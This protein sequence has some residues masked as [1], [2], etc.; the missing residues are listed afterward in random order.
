MLALLCAHAA[1]IQV[2]LEREKPHARGALERQ[3]PHAHGK[4]SDGKKHALAPA[5]HEESRNLHADKKDKKVTCPSGCKLKQSFVAH[6]DPMM[7]V[8]GSSQHFWL[9]E[10]VMT[11][12]FEWTSPSDKSSM[13]IEGKTFSRASSGNQWFSKFAIKQNGTAVCESCAARATQRATR[14]LCVAQ[15]RASDQRERAQIFIIDENSIS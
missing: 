2:S 5:L 15:R 11:P 4:K 6:A 10:G 1:G 3:K 8:N 12:L 9:T 7:K 13:A 14:S